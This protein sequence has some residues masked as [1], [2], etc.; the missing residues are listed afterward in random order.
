MSKHVES[1]SIAGSCKYCGD[2]VKGRITE[3]WYDQEFQDV[4]NASNKAL[5]KL[6][7]ATNKIEGYLE[8]ET[9]KEVKATFKLLNKLIS[10]S[11]QEIAKS[12]R[13]PWGGP[14]YV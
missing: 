5:G 3:C 10:K 6:G 9:S 14:H 4:M 12:K 11:F 1:S 8:N 7:W 2:S 13:M